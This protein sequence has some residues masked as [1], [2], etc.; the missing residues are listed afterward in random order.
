MSLVLA[1][2]SAGAGC[3]GEDAEL[4]V[5]EVGGGDLGMGSLEGL[6]ALLEFAGSGG[7]GPGEGEGALDAA[8]P[9][10]GED[11]G[12]A[13]DGMDHV[14]EDEGAGDAEQFGDGV[15]AEGV[16]KGADAE[17]RKV[18]FAAVAREGEGGVVVFVGGRADEVGNVGAGL[19]KRRVGRGRRQDGGEQL[20]DGVTGRAV[21]DGGLVNG[22]GGEDAVREG[23]ERAAPC[24]AVGRVGDDPVRVRV[25][26]AVAE[27]VV[28][29]GEELGDG[30]RQVGGVL[31]GLGM[32]VG[33]QPDA[34]KADG[35]GHLGEAVEGVAARLPGGE[36]VGG[37]HGGVVRAVEAPGAHDAVAAAGYG[38]AVRAD[39]EVR[40]G[41]AEA[42]LLRKGRDGAAD[43][44]NGGEQGEN[45]SDGKGGGARYGSESGGLGS[46]FELLEQ[47]IEFLHGGNPGV[48][49]RCPIV[50]LRDVS[51][52]RYGRFSGTGF[53]RGAVAEEFCR[54]GFGEVRSSRRGRC[55]RGGRS[56][57]R[58]S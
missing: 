20:G 24:L 49:E 33:R 19:E 5:E 53:R 16:R 32:E 57:L 34:E 55:R 6:D 2:S 35:E 41:V 38:D 37:S 12:G 17:G 31:P 9:G 8:L 4:M 45:G 46:P 13:R 43:G 14:G 48:L 15:L 51:V 21:R 22:E 42:G 47:E 50:A 28:P 30:R 10:E 44:G 26:G 23:V 27:V 39:L 25:R 40:T 58:E 7:V 11:G 18:Q 1:L 3:A 54:R 56:G 52:N 29:G 36:A